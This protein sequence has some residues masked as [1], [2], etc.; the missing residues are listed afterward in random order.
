[1]IV[2]R[3]HKSL[4]STM[5]LYGHTPPSTCSPALHQGP[6][7]LVWIASGLGKSSQRN[8]TTQC[9]LIL[10]VEPDSV[11]MYLCICAKKSNFSSWAIRRVFTDP[12]TNIDRL[13]DTVNLFFSGH[14]FFPDITCPKF[15]NFTINDLW[16]FHI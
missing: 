7:S 9:C 15:F 4:S 8:Q 16:T 2:E 12:V 6:R 1:M 13:P 3:Q 5:E 11:L 10:V 14:I